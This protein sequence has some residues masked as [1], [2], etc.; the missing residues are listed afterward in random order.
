MKIT[1]EGNFL[2]QYSTEEEYIKEFQEQERFFK[3]SIERHKQIKEK[4][5]YFGLRSEVEE[6][7]ESENFSEEEDYPNADERLV[8]LA[9][10]TLNRM[11]GIPNE[12][13]LTAEEIEELF[14]EYKDEPSLNNSIFD[15]SEEQANAEDL[16][17][18]KKSEAKK[19]KSLEKA[20]ERQSKKRGKK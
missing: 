4:E 8:R 2:C 14:S 13:E 16:E 15:F 12:N 11:N 7:A 19:I 1:R 9:L 3:E 5:K 20:D 18:W 6:R 10:E 17:N